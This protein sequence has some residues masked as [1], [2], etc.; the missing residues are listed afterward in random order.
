MG[1]PANPL[2]QQGR[3][4]AIAKTIAVA[5]VLG[6]ALDE[7]GRR[8]EG[9]GRREEWDGMTVEWCVRIELE[10]RSKVRK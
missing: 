5:Q 6:E 10:G 8:G 2:L 7:G 1:F 4:P 9:G 3:L